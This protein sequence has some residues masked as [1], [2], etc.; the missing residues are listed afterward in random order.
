MI[1]KPK[2]PKKI[3]NQDNKQPQ[4][5]QE[6][7]RRYDLDNTNIYDFLDNLVYGINKE[8]DKN[9]ISN[10]EKL[11]KAKVKENEVVNT[12]GYYKAFDGGG[13]TYLITND[14]TLTIDES[15]AIGLDN[16]LKAKL[17]IENNTIN[18]KQ[19]GARNQDMSDAKYDI[20]QYLQRYISYLDT[21]LYH[22]KLYIPSGVWYCSACDLTRVKGF[23]IV[24][25]KGLIEGYPNCT[26]ITSLNE[27]QEYV[28]RLGNGLK[29]TNNWHLDGITL[30]SNDYK[31]DETTR[32]FLPSNTKTITD[33]LLI[34]WYACF[35]LTEQLEF[36]GVIGRC[37]RICS[38]W[39]NFF[40]IINVQNVSSD[41]K[42]VFDTVDTSFIAEAN[43]TDSEFKTLRFERIT[44]DCITFESNCAVSGVHF[45][46]INLEPSKHEIESNTYSDDISAFEGVS[47]AIFNFKGGA[48]ISIDNIQCNNLSYRYYTRNDINYIYDTI[49]KVSTTT[50]E[51]IVNLSKLIIHYAKKITNVILQK[52]PNSKLKSNISVSEII[53][54]TNHDA[55]C[56]VKG[57]PRISTGNSKIYSKPRIE[58]RFIP[59]YENLKIE[60]TH[61]EGMLYYDSECENDLSL[62]V[63]PIKLAIGRSKLFANFYLSSTIMYI[64]AKIPEGS[65]FEGYIISE[66]LT[67]V[68]NFDLVGTGAYLPYKLDLSAIESLLGKKVYI[69]SRS[70]TNDID[71]SF[72]G[73][74]N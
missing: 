44:G 38:C 33:A 28:F 48:S 41:S 40:G 14:N 42:I 56:N 49:F 54:T 34:L 72:N 74:I 11:K 12:L 50:E 57:F 39:E 3:P 10:I 32:G 62:A 71:A 35:G 22:I 7:I 69:G 16:G 73:Y 25:D 8:F 24:G 23:D 27:D 18:I 5:I 31:Y 43:I 17:I 53:N 15:F 19:L 29:P 36:D 55:I 46:N 1:E 58:G 26:V 52:N 4:T 2:R 70:N 9:L 6:L 61:T 66:D 13:A 37:L 60:T 30:S 63:K 68:S 47:N 51:V 20:K 65:T 21:Q 64:I 45:G 59:F 67:A